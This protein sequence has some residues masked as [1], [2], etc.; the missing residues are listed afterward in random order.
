MMDMYGKKTGKKSVAK[1]GMHRMPDG[2]M[3][4][5]SAMKKQTK[6]MGQEVME[7]YE[8]DIDKVPIHLTSSMKQL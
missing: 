3:M 2:T 5:N 6:K 8:E 1:K 4:K 7:N